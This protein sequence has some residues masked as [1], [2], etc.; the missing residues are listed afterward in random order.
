MLF[1]VFAV[2]SCTPSEPLTSVKTQVSAGTGVV[3]EEVATGL[4]VPWDMVFTSEHRLLVT[5]RAGRIREIVDGIL[6]PKPLLVLKD[7]QVQEEAGLL[8]MTLHPQYA[9]NK[10]VYIAYAVPKA[11]HFLMH[12]VRLHDEGTQLVQDKVLMENIPS[13]Y[14]HSGSRLAFGKDGLLY[15]TTG[16]SLTPER[17]QDDTNLAG[18]V[19]RMTDDGGIPAGQKGYVYAKGLRN[20]QGIAFLPDGTLFL[21]D[22]GPTGFDGPIGGDEFNIGGEGANFGWP[23]ISYDKKQDGMLVPAKLF[24]N[25]IAPASALLY[26]GKQ[27]PQWQGNIFVGMLAGQGLMRV[28]VMQKEGIWQITKTEK[29]PAVDA[30]RIRTVTEGPDGSLY[31]TT[32]NRDGRGSPRKGDDKIL[33]LR[34]Q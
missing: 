20:S 34:A 26:T 17:A 31:L 13:D 24:Q 28:E 16:A 22:H 27:F 29:V 12:I 18:K 5:E 15:V 10:Y 11:G 19:L 1:C 33:R 30:G 23:T 21:T 8:G 6:N 3:V 7:V 32:S 14:Y 9:Q 25:S 4:E 2:V